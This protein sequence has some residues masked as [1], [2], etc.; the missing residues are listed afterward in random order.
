[1]AEQVAEAVSLLR[2]WGALAGTGRERQGQE[3][4]REAFPE[5]ETRSLRWSWSPDGLAW[6]ASCLGRPRE[7]AAGVGGSVVSIGPGEWPERRALRWGADAGSFSVTRCGGGRRGSVGRLG[8]ARS[9]HGRCS[10]PGRL[11]QGGRREVRGTLG[12]GLT[13]DAVG[14]G[15]AD[16]RLVAWK[17]AFGGMLVAAITTSSPVQM[18]TVRPGVLD[19]GPAGGAGHVRGRT[20]L[21]GRGGGSPSCRRVATTTSR[22]SCPL[23]W[24][25]GWEPDRRPTSTSGSAADG[26]SGR[27]AGGEPQG[28]RQGLAPECAPG[29]HHRAHVAP[30]SMSPLGV[31]GKFNHV[32]GT[33]RAGTVLAVN[34][35]PDAPI[36]EWADVGI[37]GDWKEVVAALVSELGG[38]A[39]S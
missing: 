26:P 19:L 12:A 25:S 11:G 3:T 16:G 1:M 15:V 20:A 14:L 8:L 30:R 21:S 39:A 2:Q 38:A 7:L 27:R 24:W 5:A 33:G 17:P 22:P 23:G 36:F 34:L 31:Q 13:G 9:P 37:V 32:I 10:S 28:H 29:R 6:L 35:D 18:A 4:V